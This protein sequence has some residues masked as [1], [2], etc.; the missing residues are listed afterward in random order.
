MATIYLFNGTQSGSA[1][2]SYADPYDLANIATA[3]TGAGAGGTCIFKDGAYTF[4][5]LVLASAI[6]T[7]MNYE[8]ETNLG[9]TLTGSTSIRCGNTALTNDCTYTGLK[10]VA[11]NAATG[12]R[13]TFDQ[14]STD[15]DPRHFFTSC[16][17][18]AYNF[19]EANGTATVE[20]VKFTKCLFEKTGTGVE[21]WFDHRN[22]SATSDLEFDGCTITNLPTAGASVKVFVKIGVTVKNTIVYDSV[23]AVT[24]IQGS[25][26]ITVNP[27]CDLIRADDTT[28][29][30]DADNLAVDPLFIDHA[31]A[32]YRLRP[33]SPCINAGA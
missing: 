10:L 33:E 12:D 6:T 17:L 3:E 20:R 13:I 2:G 5:T 22:G 29:S 9:V 4:T 25:G 18:K 21:G 16:T 28:L 23:D 31:N 32:D 1:D 30:A 8:A 14:L 24:A 11:S 27:T 7:S 15:T 26:S 19:M